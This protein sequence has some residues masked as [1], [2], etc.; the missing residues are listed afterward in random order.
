MRLYIAP[1]IAKALIRQYINEVLIPAH[2][3]AENNYQEHIKPQQCRFL[4]F[5]WTYE[6]EKDKGFKRSLDLWFLK[7]RIKIVEEEIKKYET[8]ISVIHDKD[9]IMTENE[10]TKLTE[11]G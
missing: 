10:L 8:A 3:K 1:S 2:K 7:N 11:R 9:V 6:P 5:R 4:F